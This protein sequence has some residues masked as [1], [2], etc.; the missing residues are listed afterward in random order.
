M[1]ITVFILLAFFVPDSVMAAINTTMKKQSK[2]PEGRQAI[3]SSDNIHFTFE[4][5]TCY[6]GK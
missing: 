3:K 2:I 6:E 1:H 5:E 4:N